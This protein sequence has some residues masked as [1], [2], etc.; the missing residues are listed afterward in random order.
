MSG[1]SPAVSH[2]SMMSGVVIPGLSIFLLSKDSCRAVD[3]AQLLMCLPSLHAFLDSIVSPAQTGWERGKSVINP[4]PENPG[5]QVA[6]DP[7]KS[8]QARGK[9]SEVRWLKPRI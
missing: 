2:I 7:G 4:S 9:S 3:A 6:E 5:S 1:P 8:T